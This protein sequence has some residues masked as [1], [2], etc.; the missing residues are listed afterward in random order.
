VPEPLKKKHA[1]NMQKGNCLLLSS[2]V[3][4]APPFCSPAEVV[5]QLSSS[6]KWPNNLEA[7]R[8]IRAAF[9]IKISKLLSKTYV[10]R[11]YPVSI[12]YQVWAKGAWLSEKLRRW[13]N[14]PDV[15]GSILPSPLNFS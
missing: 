11:A 12:F 13:S 3:H 1:K 6:N 15:V 2:D 7:I 9:N 14:K 8:R 4:A 5:L 10:T